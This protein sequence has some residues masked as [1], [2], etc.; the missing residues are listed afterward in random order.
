MPD[1]KLTIKGVEWEYLTG[2]RGEQT[3]LM[4]H[5]A[6]GGAETMQWLADALGDEYRTIAPT[7]A[8]VR[9]LEEVCDAASAIL[10]REHVG[11]AVLFGGSFGGLV[12]QAFLK[13]RRLQVEHLILLSTG[14][15]SPALGA[16]NEKAL[17]FMRL[18]PFPLTRAMMKLE[19]G[20]HLQ[21]P[22]TEE[23]ERVGLFRE[24]LNRYLERELTKETFVSRIALSVE[25]NR[26]ESYAPDDYT[27]WAGRVLL[28]D[29][30]DD[31]MIPAAER[32][33]LRATYPR[34]LVCT[35]DGAGHLIPILKR[36]ELVGL[37]KAFLKE[38]YGPPP[39]G[40]HCP[41]HEEGIRQ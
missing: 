9:T 7:V 37:I 30:N 25:F 31:P 12:A 14:A 41:L 40:E 18:L 23:A 11:R 5:G 15:P 13:R 35:F 19:L 8:P 29:S 1:K 34:A 2:G 33:R 36:E 4:F 17:K 27:D 39:G 16:K 22:A 10:D 24:R 20:R 32:A 38:D 28:V 6:V 21:A 26:R 3:V